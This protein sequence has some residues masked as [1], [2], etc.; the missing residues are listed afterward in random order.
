[1]KY[2]RELDSF[3]ARLGRDH[4]RLV[5]ISYW[6]IHIRLA[7]SIKH[8]PFVF[9]HPVSE[10]KDLRQIY[11][12]RYALLVFTDVVVENHAR[13]SSSKHRRKSALLKGESW[14]ATAVGAKG[15]FDAV[16]LVQSR[17]CR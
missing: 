13:R 4:V 9:C 2:N 5:Q 14:F 7:D 1:M 10:A 8:S 12:S 16:W 11:L 3:E 6:I 15:N 17:A